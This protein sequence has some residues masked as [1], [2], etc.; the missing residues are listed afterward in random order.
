MGNEAMVAG[1]R[2][3][4]SEVNWKWGELSETKPS[5]SMSF[6][7]QLFELLPFKRLSY[8]DRDSSTW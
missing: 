1:L 3:H 6:I 5:E 4:P 7:W 8:V 2:L